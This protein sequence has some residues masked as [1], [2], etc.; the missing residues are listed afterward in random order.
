MAGRAVTALQGSNR[1][2]GQMKR[3]G[4]AASSAGPDLSA[5]NVRRFTNM[6]SEYIINSNHAVSSVRNA[7]AFLTNFAWDGVTDCGHTGDGKA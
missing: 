7:V 6:Y 3:S 2:A 5:A 1:T 4:Q